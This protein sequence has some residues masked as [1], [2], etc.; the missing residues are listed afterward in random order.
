MQLPLLGLLQR[1]DRVEDAL[2]GA[3]REQRALDDALDQAVAVG[4]AMVEHA[5]GAGASDRG[6]C[7]ASKRAS[8]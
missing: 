6:A 4:V 8:Q 5:T 2:V 7:A 1:H 3:E